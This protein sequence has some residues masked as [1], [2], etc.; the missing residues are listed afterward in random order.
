MDAINLP[1]RATII[2]ELVPQENLL[3]AVSL[4]NSSNNLT[5]II[6]PALAGVLIV[7]I[8]TA[9]VFFFISGCYLFSV[10]LVRQVQLAAVPAGKE[11]K[12]IF[13]DLSS[14]LRYAIQG[15]IMRGLISVIPLPI[16][17]GFSI[18]NLLP[19]W[20]REALDA[21][22]QGLGVLMMAMGMGALVGT[23]LLAARKNLGKRWRW[24]LGT[25]IFWGVAMAFFAKSTSYS[26]ALILLFLTGV[27]MAT[28]T[29]LHMTLMQVYSS[30]EMRGRM[31]S[32][33]VMTFGLTPISA[34][35]F[36]A[37]AEKVGTHNALCLSGILLSMSIIVLAVVYP[38][39]RLI[40]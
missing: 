14:G 40:E 21:Q 27:F 37:L 36:G 31:M 8:D 2:S 35:P 34:L 6:G 22:S 32:L 4:S 11:Q 16:F 7:V 12:T 38:K 29:S 19:A 25:A 15:P 30:P 28:H 3:N 20:A 18:Q 26:T 1:S 17:F 24:M 5:R 13:G 10:L 23:L 33:V 39:F 9:G